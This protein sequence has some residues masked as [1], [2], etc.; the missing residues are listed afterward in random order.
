MQICPKITITTG[1][2][3]YQ[4]FPVTMSEYYTHLLIPVS[5]TYRPT[6]HS[7]ARFLEHVVRHGYVGDDYKIGFSS[8]VTVEPPPK[9]TTSVEVR[10]PKAEWTSRSRRPKRGPPI[11][12]PSE[13]IGLAES[14]EEYNVFIKSSLRPR[15]L[16]IFAA[17]LN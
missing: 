9:W 8:V 6:G 4:E 17:R 3:V 12:I 10:D 7:V 13:I 11:S 1:V 5:K 15:N 14:A 2:A 16:L